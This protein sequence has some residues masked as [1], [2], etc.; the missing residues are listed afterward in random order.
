MSSVRCCRWLHQG[1]SCRSWFCP[2][3]SCC[4]GGRVSRRPRSSWNAPW[5]RAG[6]VLVVHVCAGGTEELPVVIPFVTGNVDTTHGDVIIT[7]GEMDPGLFLRVNIGI[8]QG[9]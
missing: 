4:L 7:A 9:Q 2:G 5:H 1:G 3:P 8:G 6:Q